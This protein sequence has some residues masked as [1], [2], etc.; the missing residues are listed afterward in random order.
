MKESLFSINI[1][2]RNYCNLFTFNCL[3]K[4]IYT[5]IVD[6]L[7]CGISTLSYIC[8]RKMRLRKKVSDNGDFCAELVTQ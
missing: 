8:K 4:R 2:V 5:I 3:K 6:G 7:F 1:S